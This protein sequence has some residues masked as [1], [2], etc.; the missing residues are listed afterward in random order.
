M[1]MQIHGN[2][3][4]SSTDYAERVKEGLT[5]SKYEYEVTEY[6]LPCL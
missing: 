6:T 1:A 5:R 2:Y 4:H 3:D